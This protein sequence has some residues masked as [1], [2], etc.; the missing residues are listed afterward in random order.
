MALVKIEN[1]AFNVAQRIKAIN[2][3]YYLV[4]NTGAHRYEVHNAKQ[5]GSTFCITCDDGI[6][7][8]VI[9][10]L[11]KTKIENMQ[12]LLDEIEKSNFDYEQELKRVEMD[13]AEFKAREMF[14]YATHHED[15]DFANSYTTRWC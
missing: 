11:R 1:D 5:H 15:C 14:D 4:Y 3:G 2:S 10:K 8:K 9:F 6:N 7:E 12:K 13:K